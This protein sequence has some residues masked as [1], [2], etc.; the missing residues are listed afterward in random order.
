M[1]SATALPRVLRESSGV[2]WSRVVEGT[3]FSHNDGG[4]PPSIYVLDR[5]GSIRAEITFSGARNRDWEDMATAQ[6]Q[7]GSC[8]YV[9][10][11]GD[12]E[13]V[14]ENIVLYRIR[15]PGVYD[16]TPAEPD[17]FPMALPDGP[18]DMEAMFVLPGEEVFFVSKGRSHP[19]TVYRY[20]PPLREG[21]TVTLEAIQDL[22]DARLSIPRQVTGADAASDGRLVS[23]RSYEALSFF[24]VD[25]GRLVP[26]PEG[27][28]D[29]RTLN[30]SQGEAVALGPHGEVMLT[31]EG[32]L[33]RPASMVELRC[34]ALLLQK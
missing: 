28:V 32:I 4:H 23:L 9:A 1:G 12:N 11:I 15:D 22:S 20:P 31:S 14:R 18:R 33:T 2:A 16:G 3:L 5:D 24:E 17:V 6:C 7:A 25:A 30:E 10:D 21:E 26:I 34:A 19:V 27:R 29:L 13:V 8:I